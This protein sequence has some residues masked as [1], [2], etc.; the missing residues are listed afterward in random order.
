MLDS[1]FQ[2]DKIRN[3]QHWTFGVIQEVQ[4]H[5]KRRYIQDMGYTER[6]QLSDTYIEHGECRGISNYA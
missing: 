4:E 6:F 2:A 5:S 1:N 3:P